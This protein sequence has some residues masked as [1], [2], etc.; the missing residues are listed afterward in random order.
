MSRCFL[1]GGT[2]LNELQQLCSL[3][4]GCTYFPIVIIKSNFFFC[5]TASTLPVLLLLAQVHGAENTLSQARDSLQLQLDTKY[6]LQV[7]IMVHTQ[8]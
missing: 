2:V 8:T 3:R 6:C 4:Y 7:D 1:A 5:C